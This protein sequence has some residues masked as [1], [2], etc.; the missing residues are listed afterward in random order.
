MKTAILLLAS[1][2]FAPL[3]TAQ[4][5]KTLQDAK[6]PPPFVAPAGEEDLTKLIDRCAAYLQRNILYS[7]QEMTG[8]AGTPQIKLQQPVTTDRDGCEVFLSQMLHRAGF[9]LTQVDEKGTM[10]EVIALQGPRQREVLQ[11]AVMRTAED[12]L[13][14]PDLRV[15]VTV[16]LK[17]EHTNANVA[18]NSLRP[19]FASAGGQGSG[20]VIGNLGNNTAMLLSGMQDQVA[21]AIRIVRAGDVA[22]GKDWL[23]I[24]QRLASIAARLDALEGKKPEKK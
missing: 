13:T 15:P 9:A 4:D 8:A 6:G 14:R 1:I 20:L 2:T 5:H 18:T 23:D 24:E 19:F 10:L 16:V 17:L 22:G 7:N 11:R 12:V 21:Q 3:G